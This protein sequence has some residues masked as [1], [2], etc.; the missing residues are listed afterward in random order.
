MAR[1]DFEEYYTKIKIQYLKVIDM[2]KEVNQTNLEKP[3]DPQIVENLE[4]ILE[5]VKNSYSNL[6]YVE[7]LLN[8]P[9]D[10]K[11]KKRNEQQF[12]ALLEKIDPTFQEEQVIKTNKKVI[13]SG[14]SLMDEDIR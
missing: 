12:K 5:P 8:L 4:R 11:V 6:A 13:D 1:K 3:I 2:I 9:K 14:Q 7:Y 10:K